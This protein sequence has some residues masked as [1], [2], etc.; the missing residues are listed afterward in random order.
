MGE[1]SVGRKDEEGVLMIR[2]DMYGSCA[3]PG[4]NRVSILVELV[5]SHIVCRLSAPVY[6]RRSK[7][8]NKIFVYLE[9]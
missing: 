1:G 2:F 6:S 3:I 5:P 7:T 4:E 9:S 8:Y